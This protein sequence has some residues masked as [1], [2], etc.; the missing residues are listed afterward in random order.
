MSG[1]EKR[2]LRPQRAG[3]DG[4]QPT[5]SDSRRRTI[6]AILDT[7]ATDPSGESEPI[8]IPIRDRKYVALL[9]AADIAARWDSTE[10]RIRGLMD[11]KTLPWIHDGTRRKVRFDDA[12]RVLGEPP[13]EIS[14]KGTCIPCERKAVEI[15][16]LKEEAFQLRSELK[17]AKRVALEGTD[18]AEILAEAIYRTC[19]QL[20]EVARLVTEIRSRRHS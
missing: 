12:V 6:T 16:E 17:A 3:G 20:P 15:A 11:R 18:H 14:D 7:Y 19:T 4:P 10:R 13:G 9:T 2:N 5:D 1:S 8:V